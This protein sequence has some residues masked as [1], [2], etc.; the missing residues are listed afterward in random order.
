MSDV[1]STVFT[2]AVIA[3]T[4]NIVIATYGVFIRHSIIKKLMAL[5]I[6]CDSIN[7]LAVAV[8]FRVA[9]DYYPSPPV[10]EGVPEGPENI[11]RFTEVAV[12]PLPQAFVI[13]A[14][15]IGL[16][17]MTFLLSLAV[18]YYDHFKTDDIRVSIKEVEEDE[19]T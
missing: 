9:G 12:D 14:I 19:V 11:R 8:G 15:V 4:M 2:I 6:F 17:V 1:I 3:I 18:T 7:V 13:T 5:I 16:A 10:L